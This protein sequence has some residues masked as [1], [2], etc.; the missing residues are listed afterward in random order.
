MTKPSLAALTRGLNKYYYSIVINCKKNEMEQRML[1]NLNKKSWSAALSQQDYE[2]QKENTVEVM[3]NFSKL[4]AEYTKW[5][6]EE[7][8]KTEK[9][10]VVWSAGKLNPPKHLSK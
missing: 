2:V 9:E 3:K 10:F 7:N 5:I 8:K 1:L 6:Q 4:T